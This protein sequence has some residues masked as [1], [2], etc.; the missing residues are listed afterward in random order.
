MTTQID[1][2]QTEDEIS[3][4]DIYEFFAENFKTI[5]LSGLG[6]LIIGT[7]V[8]FMLPVKYEAK[9][10]IEPA[11]IATIITDPLTKALEFKSTPVESIAV[12][13]EKLKSPTY[14]SSPTLEACE[15]PNKL[16][17]ASDLANSLNVQIERNSSFVSI[18]Y[19]TTGPE[20]AQACL[21]ATL[22]D[23]IRQQQKLMEPAVDNLN[24]LFKTLTDQLVTAKNDQ[25]QLL[26]Q[27]KEKLKVAVQ[28]RLS[29]QNFVDQFSKEVLSFKFDNNQFSASALLLNTLISK[30][31]DIRQLDIEINRLQFEVDN[32]ITIR[33]NELLE[34]N[35]RLNE[36]RN[37]LAAP[38]TRTASFATPIYA[39]DQKV[40]PKR[41]IIMLVSV[42]AGFALSVMFLLGRKALRHVQAQRLA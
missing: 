5:V 18:K 36:T 8:A 21:Q 9:G 15:L 20:L 6:A 7:V 25:K 24:V 37:A 12:L 39:P 10:A 34:L 22:E 14:F 30:Q 26:L 27:N 42:F 23:V 28:K 13:A 29:D 16:V 2:P 4:I 35:K 19:R 31:N 38:S 32:K 3:L 33:D 1:T 11:Q 17:G 40:E 41:S